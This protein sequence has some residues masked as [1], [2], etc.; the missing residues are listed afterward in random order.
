MTDF[1]VNPR[2]MVRSG[3]RWLTLALK[4]PA[5]LSGILATSLVLGI[6][7]VGGLQSLELL[8]FDQM[9]RLRPSAGADPRLLVVAITEDDIRSQN[10][11]PM[12]DQVVAQLLAKLNQYKPKVI[13]LDIYRDV[14]QPPG[15]AALLKQLQASNVMTVL[16]LGDADNGGVPAPPTAPSNQVSFSDFVVDPDAVVRRNLLFATTK[17]DQL[18]SFALRLSLQYLADQ[19]LLFRVNP[20]DLQIGK[21]VFPVLNPHAGSYQALD[22]RGYQVL[23]NYRSANNVARQVTLTQVLKGE[24]QPEWVKDKL[25]LIGTTAPSGKDLFLTPYNL[26]ATQQNPKTPGVL[27]HAQ[28]ASQILGH[29]LDGNSLLWYWSE[30]GEMVWLWLWAM[31][32][33]VLAWRFRHPASLVFM[34][35]AAVGGLLCLGFGILLQSGWVPVVPAAIALILSTAGVVVYRLLHDAFHDALTG[36]PNRALLMKQLQWLSN[37]NQ[38]LRLQRDQ[39]K[40]PTIAVLF[41]GLDGFKA[42]NDSFGH[43][44]GD[45][46]LVV[47]TDRLKSCLQPDDQLARVGGDEFAIL[48]RNVQDPDEV[49]YLADQLQRQV[50]LPIQLNGQEVFSTASIGIVLGRS[51]A[52]YEPE[53]ILRDAHTAMYRAK[54]SGKARHEVFVTGMRVQVMT[55]LQLETDLRRAI[56]RQEFRLHY[57]PLIS[58]QTGKIAGFEALVRWQHPE[59]GLVPPN[60]FIPVAEET[61]LI[62]PMGQWITHE[63]C[64]QLHLWQEKF[65]QEQ[66]L[67]VSVN[68]SGKQFSQPDLV[69]QIEQ[70]LQDTGL[71]GRTLKLEITESMA[72]TDVESTIAL[73]QRLKALHLQLSIDDFGTGYS[74]LSYLHRFPTNTIK[75]DRS[76]VSRM[77]DEG[78][79]AQ[80]VQTIIILGHNLGMDIVAEGVETA[81]QLASLRGL[82]CEYGQGFFFSKPLVAE[83]AEALLQTDPQW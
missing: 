71:D 53:D 65:P 18:Y 6:R 42:I 15:Q 39:S 46:L 19:N 76:F 66:P 25:V 57:Q 61:D 70:T 41:L 4:H 8:A 43:R 67:I 72:M 34:I 5:V 51:D 63:A 17:N 75:V 13:G 31:M 36:L 74:S 7:Q 24:L 38:R 49:T 48:R 40:A 83:A 45:Q 69:E 81:E 58:L 11:W 56:E 62:I 26:S 16:L 27:I 82:K 20:N 35:I 54:A 79:D 73:L 37:P 2:A 47:T 1:R 68:L 44:L 80:I 9:V 55:R 78:E 52:G 12:S 23:L 10:R 30:P 22:D 28:M 32:G 77:G 3:R 33:G 21:A 14:P 64:R 59:R 29:V 60:D 50:T